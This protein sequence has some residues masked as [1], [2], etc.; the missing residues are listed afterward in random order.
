MCIKKGIIK[1][2][3][4]WSSITG[5]Q[6]FN[7][8]LEFSPL[9]SCG[10]TFQGHSK[11]THKGYYTLGFSTTNGHSYLSSTYTA[12]HIRW[13]VSTAPCGQPHSIP[14]SPLWVHRS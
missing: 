14:H 13:V 11:H 7:T 10:Y 8:P 5:F 2:G 3:I 1:K 4:L 12:R 9:M 6:R